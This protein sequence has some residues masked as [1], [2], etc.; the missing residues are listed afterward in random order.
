MP[1]PRSRVFL[2][3]LVLC[4]GVARAHDTWFQPLPAR[5]GTQQAE[6]ALG[7][8]N[9]FPVQETGVGAEFLARQGCHAD[10][11]QAAALPMQPARP[12]DHA[13]V[14]R[15]PPRAAR[16]WAQLVP[17]DIELEPAKVAVYLQ[18]VQASPAVRSAWRE[19]RARGLPWK[20]RYSKH[21]RIDLG[22]E[23]ASGPQA[24][25][26]AL[27]VQRRPLQG[28]GWGF[29]LLRQ[30]EPVAGQPM[31][32]VSEAGT[33]G[34]WRRTD[35]QGRIEL[36]ALP[37]GRWLLRGT[38]LRLSERDPVRWDS[39]FVT[40]VFEVAAPAAAVAFSSQTR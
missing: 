35:E 38:L 6:L 13:L 15:L 24:V 27:D 12:V 5:K 25:P 32:L 11:G 31:E 19:L 34:I 39:D 16:C 26:M 30:G 37:A 36:P 2:A 17:L 40:L 3:A 10:D 33:R 29:Q 21:A 22:T 14:L 4:A 18:E 28:G 8:G 9:R 1:C 7:T 23:P 20:E